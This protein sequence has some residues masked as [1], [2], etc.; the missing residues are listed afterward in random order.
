MF[1]VLWLTTGKILSNYTNFLNPAACNLCLLLLA[2]TVITQNTSF[3]LMTSTDSAV[4]P[5]PQP[6]LSFSC[7]SGETN[8]AV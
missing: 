3:V 6:T 4:R 7:S 2:V 5:L 1:A 8:F